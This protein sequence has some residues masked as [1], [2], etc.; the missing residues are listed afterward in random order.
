M[1]AEVV[2]GELDGTFQVLIDGSFILV[3]KWDD[4]VQESG[5]SGFGNVFIHCGEEPER[6]VRTVCGM[7]GFLHV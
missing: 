7:A 6:I 3:G 1:G 4:L 2:K 5:I